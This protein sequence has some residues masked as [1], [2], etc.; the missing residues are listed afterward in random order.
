MNK[1]TPLVLIFLTVFID[2][3]GFGILIPILPTFATKELK[4]DE[5]AIGIVIAIYSL[6]QF[7]FN[8]VFGKLSDKYG[9]RP[10][11]VISLLLN[12]VGYIVFS[13]THTYLM[14]IISRIIAGVGGSSIGVAQAYIADVTTREE[15]SKGMGLIGAAFGLGFVFGPLIGGM[16]SEYGYSVTGFVSAGFSFLA[17]LLTLFYLPESNLNRNN[18]APSKRT[19]FNVEAAKKIFS[20]PDLSI[21]IILFFILTFSVANI[22]G[23][24]ALLGFKVYH[25]TDLQNGYMYGI[26]GLSSAIVQGGL[27]NFVSKYINQ[28]R[29]ITIGSFLMMAGL[30]LLP[31]GGSLAGLAVVVVILSLGTGSLQPTLLSLISEVTSESEQ[32]ITLGLN[33]SFSALA[34]VLG[35]LWGG[36]AFEFIGYPFPFLT[37]AAFTFLIFLIS[38]FYLPKILRSNDNQNN[39]T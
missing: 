8:P 26:V 6:T 31:Y 17:F 16:L 4:V 36:F 27:L 13:F 30:A 19:L 18:V 22:Y 14:L 12:A 3:L 29:M 7:F 25:F 1:K 38:I 2:L 24:F 23:T 11:I 15:R 37:G 5:T 21:I 35:P 20:K 34:R 10:I 39:E 33:Q 32:G 28:K 9:R